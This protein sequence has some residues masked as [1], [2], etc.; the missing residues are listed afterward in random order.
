MHTHPSDTMT[1]AEPEHPNESSGEGDVAPTS[2]PTVPSE[3]DAPA[4][5]KHPTPNQVNTPEPDQYSGVDDVS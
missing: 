3:L 5:T 4:P 1:S 2:R